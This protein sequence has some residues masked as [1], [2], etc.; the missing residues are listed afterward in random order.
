MRQKRE[1]IVMQALRSNLKSK[2]KQIQMSKVIFYL[3]KCLEKE[4][5]DA[6]LLLSNVKEISKI[7]AEYLKSHS[8]MTGTPSKQSGRK[9][10]G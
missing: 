4:A 9:K 2:L 5:E 3:S 6:I 10:I 1:Q 8:Q 7:R